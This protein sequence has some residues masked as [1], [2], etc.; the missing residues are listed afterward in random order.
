MEKEQFRRLVGSSAVIHE[1]ITQRSSFII[2]YHMEGTEERIIGCSPLNIFLALLL[3]IKN[4]WEEE[5]RRE[6]KGEAGQWVYCSL[7]HG[8]RCAVAQWSWVQVTILH[9]VFQK[10]ASSLC[11]CPFA[12]NVSSSALQWPS[13]L[14]MH[15]SSHDT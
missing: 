9:C 3:L 11:K 10:G 4:E 12:E 8:V 5:G 2:I 14:S 13:L 15:Y 6:R 1:S 7:E